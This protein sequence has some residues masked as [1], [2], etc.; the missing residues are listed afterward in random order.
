[1]PIV[2][3]AVGGMLEL[4]EHQRTGVLVPP[5]DSAALAD[6]ICR[7]MAEPGLASSLAD[8]ARSEAH[9]RYS[10]DRMVAAF[11]GVYLSELTRRGSVPTRQP[12]WAAS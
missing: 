7:L 6:A 4:I 1:L 12:E 10:F 11:E 2:A 9:A 3:S 8:A 5:G